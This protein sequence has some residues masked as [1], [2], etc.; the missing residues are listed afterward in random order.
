MYMLNTACHPGLFPNNS[1]LVHTRASTIPPSHR[2]IFLHLALTLRSQ[3]PGR[4]GTR[5]STNPLIPTRLSALRCSSSSS[6]PARLFAGARSFIAAEMT[7]SCG[8]A[9]WSCGRYERT[10]SAQ[11]KS[12][13]GVKGWTCLHEGGSRS[14]QCQDLLTLKKPICDSF[15]TLFSIRSAAL[16]ARFSYSLYTSP[17]S[18]ETDTRAVKRTK[19]A[20]WASMSMKSSVGSQGSKSAATLDN[21]P[22]IS[23]LNINGNGEPTG[24]RH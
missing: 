6:I 21:I 4:S 3:F 11:M 9:L 22:W 10:N 7:S 2:C 13:I 12:A 14:G 5:R 1:Y 17:A 8:A 18:A 16:H 24:K 15:R 20:A 19:I 23:W